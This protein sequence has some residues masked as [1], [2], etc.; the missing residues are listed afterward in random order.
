M[1]DPYRILLSEAKRTELRC[2][3]GPGIAP[4]RTLTHARILLKK[5]IVA[6]AAPAGRTR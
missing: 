3:V 5:P 6:Q 1:T 4:A 2:L